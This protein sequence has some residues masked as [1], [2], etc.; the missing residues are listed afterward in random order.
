MQESSVGLASRVREIRVEKFG[1]DGVTAMAGFMEIPA[2]TWKHYESG[3]TIPAC[4]LLKFIE[5]TGVAPHWL[6]TGEGERYL[7]RTVKSDL[8]ASH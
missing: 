6:S 8:R 4:I 5:V 2:R 1:D 7:A 3:V